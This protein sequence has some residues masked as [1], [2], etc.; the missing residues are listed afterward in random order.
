M[1][2]QAT[3]AKPWRI[4]K[5]KKGDKCRRE[6]RDGRYRI[7]ARFSMFWCAWNMAKCN[8]EGCLSSGYC[9]CDPIRLQGGVAGEG[10]ESLRGLER[11]LHRH[12]QKRGW[13]K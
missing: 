5:R 7:S 11:A 12:Y 4:V 6:T 1:S 2:L 13:A 8:R 10:F 3:R 9:H